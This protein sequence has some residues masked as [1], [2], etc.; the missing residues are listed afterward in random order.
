MTSTLSS[1][2]PPSMMMYSSGSYPW[3]NTDRIVS[4]RNLPWLNE[5]VM[6]L[7]LSAMLRLG[8]ETRDRLDDV[9]LLCL[10]ELGINRQRER[11]GRRALGLGKR[12]CLVTEVRKTLLPVQRDRVI[13]FR[14]D[15]ALPQM[16]HQRERGVGTKIYY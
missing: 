15:T 2:L 13:N 10:S 5:G 9:S 1:V 14:P 4:S 7:S 11:F 12:S 8:P 6:M 16:V 3:G